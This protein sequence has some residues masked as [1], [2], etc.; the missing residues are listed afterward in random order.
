VAS[1]HPYETPEIIALPIA[2]GLPAYLNWVAA[3]TVQP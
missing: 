2:Q 1:L 3:E